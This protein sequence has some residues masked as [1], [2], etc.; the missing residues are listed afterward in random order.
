M[1]I[2]HPMDE[3]TIGN[4]FI[5]TKIKITFISEGNKYQFN[6]RIIGKKHDKIP[7]FC[8][9]KPQEA[10]IIKIQ[11]RENFRVET[12]LRIEIHE[13]ELHTIN[14]SAGGMLFSCT[15]ELPF[16]IGDEVAGK[17]Y[18]HN[19]D[20]ISFKGEI[21]RIGLLNKVQKQVAMQFTV[22][23][24]KDESKLIQFCFQKQRQLRKVKK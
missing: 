11:L 2:S 10:E 5:G 21:K 14:I 16:N 1:D 18:I 24:R 7:L 22:L 19:S 6:S 4:F 8:I 17:I 3:N 12:N 9:P 20:P 23:D 15:L 13:L